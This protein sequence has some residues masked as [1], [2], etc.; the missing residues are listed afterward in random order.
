MTSLSP[1]NSEAFSESESEAELKSRVAELVLP[2]IVA[3]LIREG[4]LDKTRLSD[5]QYIRSVILDNDEIFDNVRAIVSIYDNFIESAREAVVADRLEVAV[6]LVAVVIEHHLNSFYREA[7][8]DLGMLVEGDVTE[9]IRNSNVRDKTGWLFRLVSE[10]DM[11]DELKRQI[12]DLMELRNQIVHFKAA[13]F[14]LTDIDDDSIGIANRVSNR[15]RRL[16]FDVVL[17]LPERL[18]RFLN[19]ALGF[20]RENHSPDYKL[21]QQAMASLYPA[22]LRQ[23]SSDME[24][25]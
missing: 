20:I 23:N 19:D 2:V 10:Q 9:M 22:H 12:L 5:A 18:S 17:D 7:L 16:D 11:D 8:E 1:S 14:P 3:N 6:V 24:R 15:A 13:P 4:L 25:G 21:V